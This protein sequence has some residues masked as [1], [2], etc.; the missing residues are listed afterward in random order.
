MF[1]NR[2]DAA[3]KL[4]KKLR[5]YKNKND[6]VILAIPRGALQIGYVLSKE[7]NAP[8]EVMFTKKIGAPGQGEFAIGAVGFEHEYIEPQYKTFFNEYIQKKSEEIRKLLKERYA[9]YKGNK[10]PLALKNKIVIVTDDGVATGKTLL[11]TLQIIKSYQ[12]KKIVVAV[13]VGPRNVINQIKKEVDEVVCLE[14]PDTFLSISQFYHD[15][16]Q[17]EDDEAISLLHKANR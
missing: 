5:A 4:A 13:P 9:Q 8:L 15:F 11:L 6:V 10:P 16:A 7:L 17:V 3:E 1:I 2:F 14:R 12:P